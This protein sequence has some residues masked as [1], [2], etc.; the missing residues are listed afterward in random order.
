MEFLTNTF[1]FF[2]KGLG[3]TTEGGWGHVFWWN[4]VEINFLTVEIHIFF[5]NVVIELIFDPSTCILPLWHIIFR[6]LLFRNLSLLFTQ[7]S[8]ELQ[9][10]YLSQ[11]VQRVLSLLCFLDRQV[12]IAFIMWGNASFS[13]KGLVILWR[14]EVLGAPKRGHRDN[15]YRKRTLNLFWITLR[16]SALSCFK[17]CVGMLQL[18]SDKEWTSVL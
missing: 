17:Y 10:S 1:W 2:S 18:V 12:I 14:V 3:G 8:R 11:N 4:T 15:F 9:P 13:E 16:H 6:M 7:K 5:G